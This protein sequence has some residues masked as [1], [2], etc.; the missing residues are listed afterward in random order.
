MH[1]VLNALIHLVKLLDLVD[2]QVLADGLKK[3][4]LLLGLER[5]GLQKLLRLLDLLHL[6][7]GLVEDWVWS[8]VDAFLLKDSL[9]GWLLDFILSKEAVDQVALLAHS[10]A[11]GDLEVW[12]Q[13][14]E[15]A[16]ILVFFV[17]LGVQT[18]HFFELEVKEKQKLNC[19]LDQSGVKRPNLICW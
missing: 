16:L 19:E 13:F 15:D 8:N 7:Y 10:E 11:V 2:R 14:Q 3:L 12:Y 5:W 6:C 18:G 4:H 1:K 9:V 17:H